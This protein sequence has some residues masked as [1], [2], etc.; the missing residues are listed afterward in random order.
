MFEPASSELAA[1]R[2]ALKDA[3]GKLKVRDAL[4]ARVAELE[5]RFQALLEPGEPAQVMDGV[6]LVEVGAE[7]VEGIAE[8]A[9]SRFVMKRLDELAE[10]LRVNRD[11][12]GA[13]VSNAEN[14][15][16]RIDELERVVGSLNPEL[17][18][19]LLRLPELEQQLIELGSKVET[20]LNRE[21]VA[22]SS[23]PVSADVAA[24]LEQK[25]SALQ[26]AMADGLR[27]LQTRYIATPEFQERVAE[28]ARTFTPAT[29]ATPATPN[30]DT[31]RPP[32]DGTAPAAERTQPVPTSVEPG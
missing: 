4:G 3:L 19:P 11:V 21:G 25:V 24:L 14:R 9:R 30:P 31:E 8:R 6:A 16:A 26:L 17:A 18:S 20:L 27:D 28:F 12:I 29:P 13:F 7:G 22:G 32:A 15:V 1:T 2:D 10:E 23:E 5:K